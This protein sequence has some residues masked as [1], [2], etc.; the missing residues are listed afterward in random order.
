MHRASENL[1]QVKT[2]KELN[3]FE[4]VLERYSVSAFIQ[5]GGK[6]IFSQNR[7]NFATWF[8]V[9]FSKHV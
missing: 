4:Q 5:Q 1:F 2:I 9:K 6:Q 7:H 8:P 3:F